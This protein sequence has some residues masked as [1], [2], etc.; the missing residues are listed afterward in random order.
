MLKCNGS[1]KPKEIMLKLRP[2]SMKVKYVT[3]F[4][5]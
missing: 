4:A 5:L 2:E 3:Y 1:V